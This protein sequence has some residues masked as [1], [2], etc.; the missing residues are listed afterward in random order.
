MMGE[1]KCDIISTLIMAKKNLRKAG[2]VTKIRNWNSIISPYLFNFQLYKDLHIDTI[3]PKLSPTKKKL[4]F[5]NRTV[6]FTSPI[7]SV[8]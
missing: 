4:L 1:K 6:P 5:N 3:G 2:L 7:T 8:V